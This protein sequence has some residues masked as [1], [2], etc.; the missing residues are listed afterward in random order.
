[1][2]ADSPAVLRH[3]LRPRA[4]CYRNPQPSTQLSPPEQGAQT[5]DRG[6]PIIALKWF[7]KP[8]SPEKCNRA[9]SSHGNCTKTAAPL[10]TQWP[11]RR[12]NT[13]GTSVRWPMSSGSIR[14]ASAQTPSSPSPA[15]APAAFAAVPLSVAAESCF[16]SPSLP[17]SNSRN[18]P[19][20]TVETATQ[21][22]TSRHL[23]RS[24]LA[25][26]SR[27]ASKLQVNSA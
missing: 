24:S 21:V 12:W 3:R 13:R 14:C 5:E 23:Q 7:L 19:R 15:G 4:L 18:M 6:F 2:T 25:D 22:P 20:R 9:G 26:I 17:E 10:F 8:L 11:T 1:M 27:R 16:G